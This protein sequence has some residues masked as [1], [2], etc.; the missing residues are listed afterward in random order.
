MGIYIFN[1]NTLNDAL[2]SEQTD[3]GKE[4]IPGL[5]GKVR[6]HS[7]IFDD[8]WADIG[9]VKAFFE[10][11]LSLTDPT[12]QF[13]F[14]N[15][16]ALIYTRERYLP[17]SKLDRSRFSHSMVANGCTIN[18]AELHRCSIGV[19][20]RINAG[21]KMENVVMMGSDWMEREMETRENAALGRPN[22][23]V[24]RNCSISTAIL[25]KN[26]RIGNDVVLDPTGLPDKFGPDVDIAI[27]DGV[28]VVCKNT[29]VPDGF[30]MKA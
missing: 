29:V 24:G 21:T 6:M 23:G 9:T 10:C 26:V 19:R 2:D 16:D 18:E 20:S 22:L 28:M 7:Y 11:N 30:V 8:Y 12:P 3:F 13:N 14:F 1:A 4:I 25:D 17:T 15:E 27:R 5:L